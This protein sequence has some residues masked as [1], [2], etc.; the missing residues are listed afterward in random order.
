[1]NEKDQAFFDRLD[2]LDGGERVL[3]RRAYGVPFNQ[4]DAATM[5]LFYRLLPQGVPGW[6]ESRWFAAACL[7]CIEDAQTKARKDLPIQV[8][9]FVVS[10]DSPGLLK[11]VQRLMDSDWDETGFCLG[12]LAQIVKLLHQ[13]GYPVDCAVL[14]Q[15]LLSWNREDRKIQRRWASVIGNTNG[16]KL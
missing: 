15:D 4:S 11:R 12:K 8:A 7:H 2:E 10:Q 9:D 6:A 5:I 13:K 1:M 14:L 16:I 3:L